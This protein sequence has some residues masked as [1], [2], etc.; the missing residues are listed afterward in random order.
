MVKNTPSVPLCA[1]VAIK[2]VEN[3]NPIQHRFP[4][5]NQVKITTTCFIATEALIYTE[6]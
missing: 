6:N 1:S 5:K 4:F 2:I 3:Y